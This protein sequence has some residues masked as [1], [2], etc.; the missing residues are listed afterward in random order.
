MILVKPI[1]TVHSPYK[2]TEDMP[3]QPAFS[4]ARGSIEVSSKYAAGL[5][6]IEGFSHIIILY[7]FHESGKTKLLAKPFLDDTLRGVFAT[8]SPHRPN[9]IGL[10]VVRLVGHRDNILY[11]EGLDVLDGTPLLDI[12]PYVPN[13][14]EAGI[15]N[16]RIGWLEGKLK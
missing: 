3:I 4:R 5:K 7:H 11:V 9:H 13:F 16:V 8:R 1:G 10:S 14:D 2:K 6:D 12:K 15:G